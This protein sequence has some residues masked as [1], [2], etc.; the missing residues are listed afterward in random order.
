MS[1]KDEEKVIKIILLGDSGTGKTNLIN[2]Y[3]NLEFNPNPDTTCSSQYSQKKILYEGKKYLIDI[4]DTAGQ[5][6][7]ST[8]TKIFIKGSNIVVFVYDITDKNSF[9]NLDNWV[10]MVEELLWQ[11]SIFGLAANKSDLFSEQKVE[12]NLGKK[13]ANE[14][15]AVFWETS[16][17]EDKKGFQ[18]FINH[19]I[20]KF[21]KNYQ[22]NINEEKKFKL[23]KIKKSKNT[24]C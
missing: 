3:F 20:K 21:I 14:I 12:K 16:A 17:K 10:N 6:K 8:V 4:W 1:I 18:D 22:I 15:G 23:N 9:N 24:C 13:Y 5:E 19:L 7:F 11:N 2:A